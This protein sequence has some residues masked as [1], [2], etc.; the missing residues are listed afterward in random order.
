MEKMSGE[1]SSVGKNLL[2]SAALALGLAPGCNQGKLHAPTD[3]ERISTSVVAARSAFDDSCKRG[4]MEMRDVDYC[5]G[6]IE[7]LREELSGLSFELKNDNARTDADATLQS[8]SFVFDLAEK[9]ICPGKGD[10]CQEELNEMRN[11]VYSIKKEILQNGHKYTSAQLVGMC[12]NAVSILS[13]MGG[14]Y[15]QADVAEFMSLRDRIMNRP[16]DEK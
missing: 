4:N 10:R 2:L 5:A 7:R 15:E 16:V 9:E 13:E 6:I 14:A 8:M 12:N 3:A 1:G 11:N